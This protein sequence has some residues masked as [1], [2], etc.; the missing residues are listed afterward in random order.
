MV[1][2]FNENYITVFTTN[3]SYR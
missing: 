3:F 2:N 1:V